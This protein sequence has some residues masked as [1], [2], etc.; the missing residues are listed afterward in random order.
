MNDI[1]QKYKFLKLWMIFIAIILFI[2]TAWD[3]YRQVLYL[4][5]TFN[6]EQKVKNNG[7]RIDT[8]RVFLEK[9]EKITKKKYDSIITTLKK[10]K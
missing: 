1:E 7:E 10:L 6:T 9:D 5:R 8:N 2:N 4:P 3:I